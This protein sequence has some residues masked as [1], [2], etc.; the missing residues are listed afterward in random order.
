MKFTE[1]ELI[2]ITRALLDSAG[3]IKKKHLA[4]MSEAEPYYESFVMDYNE[5]VALARR[6]QEE[7]KKVAPTYAGA[8]NA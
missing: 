3:K 6:F 4:R 7:Q 8:E 2:L 5:T 1:K